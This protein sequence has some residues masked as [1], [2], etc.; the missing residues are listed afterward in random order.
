MAP[1]K[2]TKPK[3]KPR[4]KLTPEQK[5]ARLRA[6]ANRDAARQGKGAFTGKPRAKLVAGKAT[7]AGADRVIQQVSQEV[8]A[9]SKGML[10]KDRNGKII[11]V[12]PSQS[13]AARRAMD[14]ADAYAEVD[15]NA[16]VEYQDYIARRKAARLEREAGGAPKAKGNPRARSARAAAKELSGNTSFTWKGKE[17]FKKADGTVVEVPDRL[18][19]LKES[20][21][22]K[23]SALNEMEKNV[24]ESRKSRTPRNAAKPAAETPAAK[25]A[26]AKK[27]AAKPKAKPLS[28]AEK[29]KMQASVDSTAKALEADIKEGAKGTPKPP[30]GETP[31]NAA[32]NKPAASAK[33]SAAAK[34]VDAFTSQIK[35]VESEMSANSKAKRAGSISEAEFKAKQSELTAKKNELMKARKAVASEAGIDLSPAKAEEGSRPARNP[36]SEPKPKGKAAPRAGSKP[37]PAAKPEPKAKAAKPKVEK[38]KVEKPAAKPAAKPKAAGTKPAATAPKPKTGGAKTGAKAGSKAGT[39]AVKKQ[40][41][42]AIVKEAV[43]AEGGSARGLAGKIA[44]KVAG[45]GGSKFMK[46]LGLVGVVLTAKD[47]FDAATEYDRA[48]PAKVTG[49]PNSKPGLIPKTV[50]KN[51]IYGGLTS[52]MGKDKGKSV[53]APTAKPKGGNKKT[54]KLASDRYTAMAAAYGNKPGIVSKPSGGSKPSG[55]KPSVKPTSP[56]GVKGYRVKKGDT[57]WDIAQRNN[58]TLNTIY[59]LNPEIKKRKDAGK[60]DIFANTLVRLPKK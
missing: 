46:G 36:Q 37:A 11:N 56:M 31:A 43:K 17:Y 38:P 59:K 27:A 29:A 33:T 30:A 52:N 50:D 35:D 47:I 41:A 24:Q 10:I 42:K 53:S 5:A 58:T 8:A 3:P 23:D 60:V 16:P 9:E 25:K 34:K 51:R 2:T 19:P 14:L 57:L 6:R 48:F 55:N 26:T 21:I 39:S 54:N 4:P 7:Q 20:A 28:P 32:G 13:G 1:R 12:K 40:A 44:A 15:R 49:T 22:S 45:K 18:N